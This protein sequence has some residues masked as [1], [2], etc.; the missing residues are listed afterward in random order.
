MLNLNNRIE[1]I[2]NYFRQSHKLSPNHIKEIQEVLFPTFELS[3]SRNF[4]VVKVTDDLNQLTDIQLN[5]FAMNRSQKQIMTLGGPGTGKTILAIN[6]AK[7]LAAQDLN[8]I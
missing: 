8:V 7:E 3:G 6:R 4:E 5:A 1:Q 2:S